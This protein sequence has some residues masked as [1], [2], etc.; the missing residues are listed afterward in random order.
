MSDAPSACAGQSCHDDIVFVRTSVWPFA[1]DT[2][3]RNA[4]DALDPCDSSWHP[5]KGISYLNLFGGKLDKTNQYVESQTFCTH[6][7]YNKDRSQ[8]QIL[9][10]ASN[11]LLN[12]FC[13]W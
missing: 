12:H 10:R 4:G 11:L 6:G 2:G 9:N 8:D 3:S 5:W 1:L 7:F 13:P